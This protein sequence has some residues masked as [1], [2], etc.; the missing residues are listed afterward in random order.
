M[1]FRPDHM[2]GLRRPTLESL[3]FESTEG[4]GEEPTFLFKS[5]LALVLLLITSPFSSS[6]LD[7]FFDLL[8]FAVG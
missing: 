7:N 2:Y 3:L 5:T 8:L 6:S 1:I 4:D